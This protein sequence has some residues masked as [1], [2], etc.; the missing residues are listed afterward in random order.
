MILFVVFLTASF[1]FTGRAFALSS[2]ST[3]QDLQIHADNA[4]ASGRYTEARKLYLQELDLLLTKGQL[5]RRGR[6]I[7]PSARSPKSTAYFRRPKRITR[8]VWTS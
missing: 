6:F 4:A 3:A 5:R 1:V 7:Q 8:R 2:E